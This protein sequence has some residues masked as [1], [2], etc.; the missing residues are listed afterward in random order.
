M[1]DLHVHAL[2]GV[3]DGPASLDD[4]LVLAQRALDQD[5]SVLVAT[6]HV[7]EAYPNTSAN[8]EAGVD[9]LSA[10]VADADLDVRI[11][12]GAEI[13]IDR[14]ST[15][16]NAELAALTLGSGPYLLIESPLSP[17]IGDFVAPLRSL[18]ERGF[19]I[20]LAHPER[21]PVFQR[22]RAELTRLVASGILTSITAGSLVGQFGRTA[23]RM[24]LEMLRDGLVHNI[25]SDAHDAVRR[26][27]GAQEAAGVVVAELPAHRT[28]LDWMLHDV[29]AAVI[30]GEAIP[31][32]P[33]LGPVPPPARRGWLRSRV[34]TP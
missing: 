30:A 14:L 13:S 25:A 6:P 11:V 27:P 33:P 32:P 1:I 31:K 18:R 23:R 17:S 22:D 5:T 12:G 20:V 19:N 7:S 26:P 21:A 15:L 4:A 24:S 9:V 10:A 34:S 29:P 28:R 2:P 8:I 3:D 16:D